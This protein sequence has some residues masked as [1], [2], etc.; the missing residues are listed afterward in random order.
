MRSSGFNVK[1]I[2]GCIVVSFS[3][4]AVKANIL[5]PNKQFEDKYISQDNDEAL[6]A[7]PLLL[8]EDDYSDYVEQTY[9]ID[10]H[11]GEV[12]TKALL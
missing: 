7:L 10:K 6:G 11:Y 2:I 5:T 4:L 3:P 1:L 9:P 8:E 12:N